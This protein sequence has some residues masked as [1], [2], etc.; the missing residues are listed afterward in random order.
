MEADVPEKNP[1]AVALGESQPTHQVVREQDGRIITAC[2]RSFSSERQLIRSAWI[3][4]DYRFACR[5]CARATGLSELDSETVPS[6]LRAELG[7]LCYVEVCNPSESV[8]MAD[9]PTI[10]I[11]PRDPAHTIPGHVTAYFRHLDYAP[12]GTST[13][14][15]DAPLLHFS[16]V[17]RGEV[18]I[19]TVKNDA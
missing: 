4:V 10:E 3:D 5:D 1:S 2:G 11:S 12:A 13:D 18:H 8:P 9:L 15:R 14:H 7:D 6:I 16:P 19:T 17:L